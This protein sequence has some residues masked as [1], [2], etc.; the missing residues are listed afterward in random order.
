M[1]RRSRE[2]WRLSTA[3]LI[4]VATSAFGQTTV[5]GADAF[6]ELQPRA[7]LIAIVKSLD[8]TIA[9]PRSVRDVILCPATRIKYSKIGIRR[10]ES[11][12]VAFSMN[13]RS[14]YGGYAGRTM[15]G[16]VF[17]ADRL[18]RI[19]KAQIDN[20]EGINHLINNAIR[21]QMKDCPAVSNEQLE[22]LLGASDRPTVDV[23]R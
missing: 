11:W 10:P 18:P 16:A 6:P 19:A 9:D 3:C 8:S 12:Y 5:S 21:K 15:Y 1:T 13:V 20:D 4:F 7:T 2:L 17:K 23:S 14:S 22:E